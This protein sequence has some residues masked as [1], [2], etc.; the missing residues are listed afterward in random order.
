M[1]I[2]GH[3]PVDS[4]IEAPLLF[5]WSREKKNTQMP[6]L[7]T[8]SYNANDHADILLNV[9]RKRPKNRKRKKRET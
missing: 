6:L 7:L 4:I 5:F 3:F 2:E 1:G 9:T 8:P